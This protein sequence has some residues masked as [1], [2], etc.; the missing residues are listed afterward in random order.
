MSLEKADA[1]EKLNIR[2]F[3]NLVYIMI[4]VQLPILMRQISTH[5]AYV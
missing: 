1:Q 5:T 2:F 4:C 3:I